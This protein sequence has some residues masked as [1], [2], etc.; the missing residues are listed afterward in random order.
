MRIFF[1]YFELLSFLN[2]FFGASSSLFS[3][4]GF[5]FCF[6]GNLVSF[7]TVSSKVLGIAEDV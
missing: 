5:C 6:I 4:K 2:C 3:Q 7:F 1:E